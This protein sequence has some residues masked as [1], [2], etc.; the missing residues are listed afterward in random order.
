MRAHRFS[1]AAPVLTIVFAA[2]LAAALTVAWE[3]AWAQSQFGGDATHRGVQTGQAPRTLP[4][5]K[6]SFP[7]GDR[8]VSSPAFADGLV[9]IGSDDGNLYAI[10]AAS[11]R[12]RWV[13]R[14]AGPVD[15]QPA[16]SGGTC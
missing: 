3:P 11:G 4:Q 8:V 15:Y 12:Q 13:H 5:L 9:Y 10:D 16:V 14:T 2:L 7:T 6:W 1:P